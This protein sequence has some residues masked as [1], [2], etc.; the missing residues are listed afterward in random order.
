VLD[1]DTHAVRIRKVNFSVSVCVYLACCI[2]QCA[3]HIISRPNLSQDQHNING[4]RSSVTCRG[5]FINNT[6]TTYSGMHTVHEVPWVKETMSRYSQVFII[7]PK[8]RERTERV[9]ARSMSLNQCSKTNKTTKCTHY[10][11]GNKK[12]I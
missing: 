4:N 10:A 2:H 5:S 6:F 7:H 8:L 3:S 12:T 11:K 9:K 1:G